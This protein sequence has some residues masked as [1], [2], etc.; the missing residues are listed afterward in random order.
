MRSPADIFLNESIPPKTLC[1][2]H[3]HGRHA[4]GSIVI[5]LWRFSKFCF[6]KYKTSTLTSKI[7]ILQ[8]NGFEELMLVLFESLF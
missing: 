5:N 4:Y 3:V 1:G 6:K 8:E 7:C 2:H